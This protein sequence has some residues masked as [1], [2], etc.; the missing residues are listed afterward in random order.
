VVIHP[1]DAAKLGVETSDVV[2]VETPEGAFEAPAVVEPT[3]A[4]GVIMVPYGMG[5]CAD[6]VVVKPKYFEVKDPAV[7]RF[8][9]ELPERVEI[10]EDA[11][12]PAKSLPELVKKI[13]FTKS[14]AEY[15]EKGLAPDKWRFNGVTANVVQLGDSSLGSWPLL[16]WLGAGQAC[17][18]TPAKIV[19]T[20]KKHNF[21][22]PYIVW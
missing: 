9:A 11:V 16:M 6:T 17:L 18:D 15:Y 8:V 21:E 22:V 20:G 7:A 19:K 5:R 2:R 13:L 12:N 10:P 3:V 1:A 4:P 14:P